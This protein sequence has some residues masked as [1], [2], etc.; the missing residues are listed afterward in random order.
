MSSAK[1]TLLGFYNWMN[2]AGQDLFAAFDD[3]PAGVDK[4]DL[5]ANILLRG[6]EFEVLYSDPVF[7]Q[8]AITP[9]LH[10]WRRTIEKWITA[11]SIQ[12]DPLYNYDRTEEW[13]DDKVG[14]STKSRSTDQSDSR[15]SDI[16]E[17]GSHL[18]NE[19]A[20]K[21]GGSDTES[22]SINSNNTS[23]HG[24]G[25]ETHSGSVVTETE[26]SAFDTSSYSPKEQVTATDTTAV[27]TSSDNMTVSAGNT[28]DSQ[29]G[30]YNET[31]GTT[32]QGTEERKRSGFEIGTSKGSE[33]ET[34]SGMDASVHRGRMYGNIG[35][36]T[37]QEM[38]MSELEVARF[39]LIDQ[40]TDLFLPEFIIPVYV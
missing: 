2:D 23:Q 8:Q 15:A 3:L 25:N 21:N 1:I 10:K 14:S 6:G 20:S 26:V 33:D 16:S 11:L 27:D 28:T 37:T 19:L 36:T 35:V 22:S 13:T 29:S 17:N 5:V 38:L 31:T 18:N 12:Y 9:W 30:T 34:T 4:D 39:N 40:I 32:D 24:I 7:M